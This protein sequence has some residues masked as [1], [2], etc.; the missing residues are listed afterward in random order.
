MI[1]N[2]ASFVFNGA[3]FTFLYTAANAGS[4]L[5]DVRVDGV[6]AGTINMKS[7]IAKYKQKFIWTGAAGNHTVQ[8]VLIAAGRIHVD[9]ITI[10]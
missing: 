6:S 9:G 1:G 5:V 2:S 4:T 10:E 8:F 3:K 7:S